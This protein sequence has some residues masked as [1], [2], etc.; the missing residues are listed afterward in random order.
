IKDWVRKYKGSGIEGLKHS[1]IS[2]EKISDGR[3][4]SLPFLYVKV[5]VSC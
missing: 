4:Y 3:E 1:K 2:S 5:E